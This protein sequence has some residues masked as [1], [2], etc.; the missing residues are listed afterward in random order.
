M[1]EL[2]KAISDYTNAIK[3]NPKYAEAYNNRG[4]AF[5]KERNFEEA[6]SDYTKA[7]EINSNF[8]QSYRNRGIAYAKIRKTEEAVSDFKKYLKLNPSDPKA[9]SLQTYIKRYSD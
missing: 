7:L 5:F 1:N 9:L 2:N 4:N 6:I 8:I 3:I